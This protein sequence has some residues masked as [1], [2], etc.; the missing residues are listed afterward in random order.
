LLD[1]RKYD[2]AVFDVLG[3]VVCGGFA[4]PLRKGI[5]GKVFIVVSEESMALFAAN[6]IAKAILANASNGA[7]LAG[8]VAN[9]RSADPGRLKRIHA[10]A[11]ALGTSVVAT[12]ERSDAIADAELQLKTAV[13]TAPESDAARSFHTLADWALKTE[14]GDFQNPTPLGHE[15]FFQFMRE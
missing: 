14:P 13:E 7:T 9:L 2:A 12:L 10:L 1:D 3:D 15:E 8:F 5:A 6:N 11:K 4:A